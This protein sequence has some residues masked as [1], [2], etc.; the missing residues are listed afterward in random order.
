MF[1]P[2]IFDVTVVV[3]AL[4]LTLVFLRPSARRHGRLPPGPKPGWLLG[5]LLDIPQELPWMVYRDWA[6]KYG[7]LLAY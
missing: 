2:T 1:E 5:N 7:E 3:A 4:G 6:Q